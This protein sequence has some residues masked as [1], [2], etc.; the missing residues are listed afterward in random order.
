MK[1]TFFEPFTNQFQ[2]SKTLRFELIPQGKTLDNIVDKGLLLQDQNRANSYQEMKKTID[3]YH[4]WFIELALKNVQLEN[5]S[6]YV[7][8]IVLHA[9]RQS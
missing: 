5:L 1:R 6:E 2:L 7:C 3:E 4:K 8:T 9:Q